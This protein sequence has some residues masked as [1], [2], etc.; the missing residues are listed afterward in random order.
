[1]PRTQQE[2]SN[3]ACETYEWRYHDQSLAFFGAHFGKQGL[4]MRIIILIISA[5]PA[6][7]LHIEVDLRGGDSV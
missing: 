2:I 4:E 3:G 5:G 7:M 1:M 6:G